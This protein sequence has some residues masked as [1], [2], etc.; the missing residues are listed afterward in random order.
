[1]RYLVVV[2]YNGTHYFGWQKQN[3]EVSVQAVIEEK[4][5]TL[6]NSVITIHASGRTDAKVHALAQTFHFDAPVF[7]LAKLKYALNRMLPGDI[8]VKRIKRVDSSFHARFAVKKKEYTYLMHLKPKDPFL[9]N[10]VLFYP[11][12]FDFLLIKERANDFVGSYNF[13]NFTSKKEDEKNFVRTIFA[14]DIKKQ[15]AKITFKITGTGFMRGQIR[16][17]IGALLALNEKREDCDYIKRKLN[18]QERNIIAY[19]VS[20]SGLYLSRVEY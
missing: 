14:F 7:G 17:M 2:S 10:Q 13:Q 12:P 4:L 6:F 3:D 20:G 1:M 11:L 16:M 15:G 9:E 5:S 19:K 8:I 18:E